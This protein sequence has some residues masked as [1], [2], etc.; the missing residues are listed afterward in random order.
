[1]YVPV[2]GVDGRMEPSSIRSG[3]VTAVM[4]PAIRKVRVAASE[5]MGMA[6][7]ATTPSARTSFGARLFIGR[8]P[9]R[10]VRSVAEIRPDT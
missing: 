3:S 1:M 6:T 10:T 8:L 9:S 4:V 7:L 5:G 2:K